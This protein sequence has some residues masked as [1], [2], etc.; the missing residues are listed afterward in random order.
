MRKRRPQKRVCRETVTPF[1]ENFS[2]SHKNDIPITFVHNLVCTCLVKT[3]VSS[4]D[5][6]CISECLPNSVYDRQKFAA[7]TIR[8]YKPM[9]TIL[10]FTSGK[11]VL[12]GCKTYVDCVLAALQVTRLLRVN[13]RGIVFKLLEINVQNIV[14]NSDLGL[15]NNQTVLLDKFRRDFDVN[16]TYQKNM[17][18]GLIYRSPQ[19]P[20]VLLIFLSGKVVITGAKNSMDVE[21]GWR[22]VWPLLKKYVAST[23]SLD[24]SRHT[25][26]ET[27]IETHPCT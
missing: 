9:C 5:L 11:M 23:S 10:L 15:Q 2:A 18:P 7:V 20:V 14:A 8:L 12:T 16:C 17:F 26:T 13:V 27:Q 19:C 22:M 4:L 3:S 25:L 21:R 6:K 24:T 1:M